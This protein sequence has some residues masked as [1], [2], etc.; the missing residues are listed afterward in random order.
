MKRLI[1]LIVLAVLA[2]YVAWPGWTG[3]QVAT[4]IKAKDS[5]TLERKISFNDVRESL[6]PATMQKIGEV[7]DSFKSQAGP[8][9]AAIVAQI[10]ADVVPKIADTALTH[11]VTAG[12]LIRVVNDG[13]S[14]KENAERILQEQVGKIGLPG[15]GGAGLGSI[16]GKPSGGTAAGGGLQL[17]GGLGQLA[18]K[19]GLDPK[20]IPGLGGGQI[21][22][23]GGGAAPKAE[24]SAPDPNPTPSGRPPAATDASHSGFGIANIKGFRFLGPMAFE[25]GVAKDAKA[26]EHDVMVEMRF[27]GGD[28]RVVGVRPRV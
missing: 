2:F 12:N 27:V 14:L 11:L 25:I 26:A 13:G 28:W 22:G 15:L 1:A 5:A 8:A 3:Y 10:K 17:P 7:Y 6:K 20:Q 24:T 18:G 23:L 19:M 4:A 9:G 16:A 21:P